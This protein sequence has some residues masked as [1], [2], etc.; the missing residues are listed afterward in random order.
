MDIQH[1]HAAWKCGMDRWHGHAGL[2]FKDKQQGR[3][4]QH[5]HG[6]A[7]PTFSREMQ[8]EQGNKAWANSM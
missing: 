6:H 3:K 4:M 2:H 8:Q 1:G 7:A 5:C